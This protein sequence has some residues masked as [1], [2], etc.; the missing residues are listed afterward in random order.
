MDVLLIV[1]VVVAILWLLTFAL[2]M[3]G[4]LGWILAVALAV[5]LLVWL[6][7]KVTGRG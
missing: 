3:L 5:L 7:L 4:A 6:V 1:I 2:P